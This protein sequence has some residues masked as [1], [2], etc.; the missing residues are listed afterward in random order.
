MRRRAAGTHR[1]PKAFR[2]NGRQVAEYMR[3]G[4]AARQTMIRRLTGEAVN[5]ARIVVDDPVRRLITDFFVAGRDRSILARAAGKARLHPVDETPFRLARSARVLRA[6]ERLATLGR[7]Y[8][9]SEA[10]RAS[11]R[12]LIGGLLVN[13]TPAFVGRAVRR[14][15]APGPLCAVIM[16]TS[17]TRSANPDELAHFARVECEIMLRALRAAGVEVDECWYFDLPT[18]RRVRRLTRPDRAVWRA[19]EE[20]CGLVAG[21]AARLIPPAPLAG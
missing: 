9:F 2:L 8:R 20:S 14:S 16:N 11:A 6:V 12:V 18:M 13:A 17:E 5:A 19:I 7:R 10:R 4:G 3:K 1:G 15:G 21:E